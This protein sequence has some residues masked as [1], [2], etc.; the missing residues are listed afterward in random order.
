MPCFESSLSTYHSAIP[1]LCLN[2]KCGL[3]A[4]NTPPPTPPPSVLDKIRNRQEQMKSR[5]STIMLP[6]GAPSKRGRGRGSTFAQTP[7]NSPSSRLQRILSRAES[8]P[9]LS[10]SHVNIQPKSDQSAAIPVAQG[11]MPAALRVRCSPKRSQVPQPL[12]LHASS[13][14]ENNVPSSCNKVNTIVVAS[15]NQ[16]ADRSRSKLYSQKRITT[17]MIRAEGIP[18]EVLNSVMDH[19]YCANSPRRVIVDEFELATS[20]TKLKCGNLKSLHKVQSLPALKLEENTQNLLI[21]VQHQ[22]VGQSVAGNQSTLIHTDASRECQK[23]AVVQDQPSHVNMVP[24][25]SASHSSEG[26]EPYKNSAEALLMLVNKTLDIKRKVED[27]Q[28]LL[29]EGETG[30]LGNIKYGMIQ[31]NSLGNVEKSDTV[32]E[33]LTKDSVKITSSFTPFGEI[34]SEH[35][36]LDVKFEAKD[37]ELEIS[38]VECKAEREVCSVPGSSSAVIHCTKTVEMMQMSTVLN[39]DERAHHYNASPKIASVLDSSHLESRSDDPPKL[40]ETFVNVGLKFDPSFISSPTSHAPT[41]EGYKQHEETAC[42]NASVNTVKDRHWNKEV[43]KQMQVEEVK[44]TASELVKKRARGGRNVY[45][46]RGSR[47]TCI[48]LQEKNWKPG[49]SPIREDTSEL[50]DKIPSYYTA[51][52]IPTKSGRKELTAEGLVGNGLSV[53]DLIPA[54]HSPSHND[55][56]EYS[57]LP[58]YHSCFTNSTKYDGDMTTDE[59]CPRIGARSRSCSPD[60]SPAGSKNRKRARKRDG[61]SSSSSSR[62][63]SL[64]RSCKRK[65]HRSSSSASSSWSSRSR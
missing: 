11:E 6:M 18:A 32:K 10:V 3:L 16:P 57:K 21:S 49:N 33:Q 50:F 40:S 14:G 4:G 25:H 63:Q 38:D 62:S 36:S 54:D 23:V 34:P 58:A 65:R 45:C 44:L 5:T 20:P 7:L 17:V 48:S 22:Q 59:Q 1:G 55:T 29:A 30:P 37:K 8:V 51:L 9:A 24:S 47:Q 43:Q 41:Q 2:V 19:D 42:S 28:I 13:C 60:R 31:Y 52:V 39:H 27:S 26:K 61:S 35:S 53:S 46:S 56:S 64:S 15:K 12:V